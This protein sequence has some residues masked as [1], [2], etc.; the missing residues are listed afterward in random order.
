[1][2]TFLALQP[3]LTRKHLFLLRNTDKQKHSA[4]GMSVCSTS[5]NAADVGQAISDF[6]QEETRDDTICPVRK[7]AWNDAL[8]PVPVREWTT[9][10]DIEETAIGFGQA[11][12]RYQ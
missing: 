3:Q 11:W 10:P 7:E 1:M 12:G 4:K 8:K 5:E 6:P 2:Q 9:K